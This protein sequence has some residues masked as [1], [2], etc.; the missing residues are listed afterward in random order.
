MVETGTRRAVG[1]ALGRFGVVLAV[2]W[3]AALAVAAP[4]AAHPVVLFTDPALDSAVTTAPAS[5]TL[6]FNE[7]VTVSA[8]AISVTDARDESVPMGRATTAKEGTVVTAKVIGDLP[9]GVY[10]VAWQATGV[11]GHGVE[12]SSGSPSAP[13][14][15][16]QGRPAVGRPPTGRPQPCDGCCWPDSRWPWAG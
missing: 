6:V 1:S 15:P 4:A 8:D 10:R 12:G 2:V 3:G 9:R 16:A 14:S 13:R 7:A 5:V 11:D